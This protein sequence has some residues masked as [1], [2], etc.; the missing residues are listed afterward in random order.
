VE[1]GQL[2]VLEQGL[3]TP[4]EE[5]VETEQQMVASLESPRL[6]DRAPFQATP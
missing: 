3:A 1:V 5:E 2:V 4:L 6:L